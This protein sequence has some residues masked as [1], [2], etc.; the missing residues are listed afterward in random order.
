[1]DQHRRHLARRLALAAALVAGVL[2]GLAPSALAAP[3][4][5]PPG[6]TSTTGNVLPGLAKALDLGPAQGEHPMSLLVSVARPDPAGERALLEAE[7]DPHS[8][9]YHHYLSTT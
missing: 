8:D 5:P 2:I 3:A 7:Y 4:D 9:R 6:G 1:M